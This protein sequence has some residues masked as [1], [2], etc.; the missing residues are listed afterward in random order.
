MQTLAKAD[1]QLPVNFGRWPRRTGAIGDSSNLPRTWDIRTDKPEFRRKA[2]LLRSSDS[3]KTWLVDNPGLWMLGAR[4]ATRWLGQ[5]PLRLSSIRRYPVTMKDV[6]S[7]NFGL[8][9]AYV[10]PGFIV[11]WGMEP[12]SDQ[13]DYEV[14]G[15][16]SELWTFSLFF[17]RRLTSGLDL[18]G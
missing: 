9:I 18:S 13:V 16:T 3:S 1:I 10:L 5:F 17:G 2:A 4:T 14:R 12:Y 6:T 11:L 8:L 7:S 15:W